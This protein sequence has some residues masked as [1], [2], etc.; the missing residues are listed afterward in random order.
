MFLPRP[1]IMTLGKSNSVVETNPMMTRSCFLVG[2]GVCLVLVIGFGAW[3]LGRFTAHSNRVPLTFRVQGSSMVPTLVGDFRTAECFVCRLVWLIEPPQS[4]PTSNGHRCAHCGS[5]MTTEIVWPSTRM[6]HSA[7]GE[8]SGGEGK[9]F[10]LV[11]VETMD[12]LNDAGQVLSHGD[13]VAVRWEGQL[14]VKRIVAVPGDR[15][16]L[17]ESRLLVN[18]VRVE[19]RLAHDDDRRSAPWMLVDDD[20]RRA[21]SRWASQGEAGD[22]QEGWMRDERGHWSVSTKGSNTW[23][24]YGS[25]STYRGNL[26]APIRDDYPFNVSVERKLFDVDRLR[27]RGRAA[28]ESR[29]EVAFW[30]A[31]GNALARCTWSAGE[32]FRVSFYDGVL[33]DGLPVSPNQPLAIRAVSGSAG[34]ADLVIERLVEYRLRPNDD[35]GNYPY[36]LGPDEWFLLGDN[37]PVSTDSRQWGKLPGNSLIGR[38][39]RR[40]P[41]HRPLV[42]AMP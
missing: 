18:G 24:V 23:L 8:S 4:P 41:P 37:V 7:G 13:L 20:S 31:D 1:S 9:S 28:T 35:R 42:F 33:T 36:H 30:S 27:L 40:D 38:V 26:P 32:D 19:D 15:V 5:P 16:S 25:R 14:H 17:R 6:R 22:D 39:I 3:R 11:T 29:C 34:L 10:S 21:E 2:S 12:E